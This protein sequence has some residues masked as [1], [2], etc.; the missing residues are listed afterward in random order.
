M[1]GHHRR[2]NPFVITAKRA[3]ETNSLGRIIAINGLWTT[4]KPASYFAPPA[5]WRA[6]SNGG[7]VFIN[8]IHEVDLLQYLVGPIVRVHAEKTVTQRENHEAEEGA[9]VVFRFASGCV[10]TFL[11]SDAVPSPYTFEAGTGENPTIPLTKQ[12]FYRIFG[13]EA[14]LSVPD[15]TRWSYAG[16]REK[17]WTE[18]M[19]YERMRIDEDAAFR[20]ADRSSGK[21]CEGRG[22]SNLYGPGWLASSDCL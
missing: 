15:L 9:A 13:T 2:F 12:D 1:V 19:K 20:F 4:Y 11:L 22:T 16:A 8:L 21:G 3:I 10:G 6:S 17:S 18:K 14:C 5:E 7:P